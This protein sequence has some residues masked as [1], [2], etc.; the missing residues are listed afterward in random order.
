[1]GRSGEREAGVAQMDD[2]RDI[3]GILAG[4]TS[5]VGNSGLVL[6]VA[7]M[8]STSCAGTGGGRG[9]RSGLSTW[10]PPPG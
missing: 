6:G 4:T 7:T 2:V 9:G 10:L 8:S 1:M 5:C 3:M